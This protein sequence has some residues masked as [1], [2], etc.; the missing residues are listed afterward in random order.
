MG[1]WLPVGKIHN[2]SLGDCEDVFLQAG[3]SETRKD[4]T[5]KKQ[6]EIP[7]WAALAHWE[8]REKR[9]LGTGSQG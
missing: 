7:G 8:V 6:Q 9:A 3:D 2:T 4:L 1:F 5:L